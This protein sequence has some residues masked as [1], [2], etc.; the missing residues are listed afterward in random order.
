VE[1]EKVAR[2]VQTMLSEAGEGGLETMVVVEDVFVLVISKEKR[3][4]KMMNRMAY[5]TPPHLTRVLIGALGEICDA[6][7]KSV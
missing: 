2:G 5:T 6:V 1:P 7:S 4:T 3:E